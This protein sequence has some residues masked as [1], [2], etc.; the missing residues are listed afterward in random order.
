MSLRYR[1]TNQTTGAV[2][3][4]DTAEE[5]I[6]GIP[7]TDEEERDFIFTLFDEGAQTEVHNE[8]GETMT[9][10]IVA[11]SPP[12]AGDKEGGRRKNRRTKIQMRTRKGG[13]RGLRSKTVKRVGKY[14]EAPRSR[15]V[16]QTEGGRRRQSHRCL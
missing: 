6:T 13:R 12:P 14:Q 5:A 9:V 4:Y 10:T 16:F 2:T 7:V 8:V 11:P 3:Y 1:V 15:A